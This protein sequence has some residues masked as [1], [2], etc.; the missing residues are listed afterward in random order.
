MKAKQTKKEEFMPIPE[1]KKPGNKQQKMMPLGFVLKY[2][3][4]VI[5]LVYKKSY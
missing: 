4:P 5:G 1:F 2:D 3:P